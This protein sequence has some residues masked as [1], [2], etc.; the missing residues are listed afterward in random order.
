MKP[1][2]LVALIDDD[3]VANF[4]NQKVIESTH[5]VK[6]IKVFTGGDKAIEFLKANLN[7]IKLLPEIILLD[8]NMPVTDGF[9]FWR[10]S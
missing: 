6:Q 1:I 9:E 5:L 7:N 8:M 2:N 10:N 3:D 4:V